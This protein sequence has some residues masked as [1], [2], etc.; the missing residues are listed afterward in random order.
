[1]SVNNNVT[2]DGKTIERAKKTKKKTKIIVD[3][4]LK[5]DQNMQ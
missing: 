2:I 5:W 4:K 3:S 1:M